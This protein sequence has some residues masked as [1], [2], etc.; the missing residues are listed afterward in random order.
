M[1]G[2]PLG[3]SAG[4]IPIFRAV[5]AMRPKVTFVNVYFHT[6]LADSFA[7]GVLGAHETA[8][9]SGKL[10]L[11]LVGRRAEEGRRLLAPLGFE[12]HEGLAAAVAAVAAAAEQA[13]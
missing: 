9:L 10:I 11:R 4:L 6:A 8:P 2:T 3:G 13:R 5:A 12:S 1:A 7:R